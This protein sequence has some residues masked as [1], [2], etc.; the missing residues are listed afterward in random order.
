M[1]TNADYCIRV[2]SRAHNKKR[3]EE[4]I[5]NFNSL[6]KSLHKMMM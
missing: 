6:A 2:L 4:Y 3:W 1:Y 5:S